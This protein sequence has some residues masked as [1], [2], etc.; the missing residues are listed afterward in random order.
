MAHESVHV[1]FSV[2][3]SGLKIQIKSFHMMHLGQFI[4]EEVEE[5]ENSLFCDP[6]RVVVKCLYPQ[7]QFGSFGLGDHIVKA[8][9]IL[10]SLELFLFN[11]LNIPVSS[12]PLP[13]L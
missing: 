10:K 6:S 3:A 11:I 1:R 5:E 8:V 7:R 13:S 4:T 9:S 12:C 2:S